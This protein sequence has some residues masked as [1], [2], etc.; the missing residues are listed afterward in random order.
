[1]ASS[2][3]LCDMNTVQESITDPGYAGCCVLGLP[4]G[5]EPLAVSQKGFLPTQIMANSVK[6]NVIVAERL[7]KVRQPP[8]RSI[9]TVLLNYQFI[10]PV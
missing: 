10:W 6:R 8:L 1:M 5:C 4:R 9:Y 2:A 7:L 3:F